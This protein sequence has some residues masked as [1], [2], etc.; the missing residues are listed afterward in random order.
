MWHVKSHKIFV[1][2]LWVLHL[3]WGV[4]DS[5]KLQIVLLLSKLRMYAVSHVKKKGK[6][7]LCVLIKSELHPTFPM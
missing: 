5:D 4:C 6:Y 1:C 3:L 2:S 7:F